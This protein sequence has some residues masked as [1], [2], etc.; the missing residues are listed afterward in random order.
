MDGDIKENRCRIHLIHPVLVIITK[1]HNYL[2]FILYFIILYLS[3]LLLFPFSKTNPLAV[4]WA[5]FARNLYSVHLCVN[6]EFKQV[7]YLPTI[8]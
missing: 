1:S 6:S 4:I 8:F 3:E 2:G 7:K 5:H